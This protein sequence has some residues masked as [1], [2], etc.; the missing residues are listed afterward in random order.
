MVSISSF[1]ALVELIVC[2]LNLTKFFAKSV[3]KLFEL[4]V[5]LETIST[6]YIPY[7]DDVEEEV[8]VG[9]GS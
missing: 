6:K 2:S 9:F 8:L 3:L 5:N 7:D 1:M 4:R